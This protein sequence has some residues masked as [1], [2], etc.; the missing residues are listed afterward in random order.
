MMRS[1]HGVPKLK[2]IHFKRYVLS[3]ALLATTPDAYPREQSNASDMQSGAMT[4]TPE[5]SQTESMAEA[6]R[7]SS[8]ND[9]RSLGPS[10]RRL[11]AASHFLGYYQTNGIAVGNV[12]H[13]EGINLS[14]Y[15]TAFQRKYAPERTRSINILKSSGV[16][17]KVID[18]NVR[19]STP[20]L[21]TIARQAMMDLAKA[22]GENPSIKDGCTYVATHVNE[23]VAA[24]AYAADNPAMATLLME[25]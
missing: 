3:I 1:T 15:L 20:K 12:C 25:D 21:E 22:L 24:Q 5:K 7:A 16:T 23:A 17:Q 11:Y 8:Q 9:I 14:S 13:A 2:L 6:S 19:A 10:N 18:D 4:S